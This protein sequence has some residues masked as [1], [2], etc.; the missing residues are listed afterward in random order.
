MTSV[1]S[2]FSLCALAVPKVAILFICV[3]LCVGV[4]MCVCVCVRVC[5]ELVCTCVWACLFSCMCIP[6]HLRVCVCV[7]INRQAWRPLWE[8]WSSLWR[9]CRMWWSWP[10]SVSASLLW[11]DCSSS[12]GTCGRSVL[13]GQST[14]LNSTWQMAAGGLIGTNTSWMTVSDYLDTWT[15]TC[16]WLHKCRTISFLYV[17]F[18]LYCW[19]ERNNRQMNCLRLHRHFLPPG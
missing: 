5:F 18:S 7:Y 13:S 14:W 15:T 6:A 1:S 12:W 11:L 4:C 9:S 16:T 2:E 17:T 10:S 3:Y 19:Y 8:L